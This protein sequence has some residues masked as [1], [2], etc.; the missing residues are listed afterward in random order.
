MSRRLKSF[1]TFVGHH[2]Y[3]FLCCIVIGVYLKAHDVCNV[4]ACYGW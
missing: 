3:A 1:F 2:Q 4:S